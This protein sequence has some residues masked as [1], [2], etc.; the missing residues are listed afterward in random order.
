MHLSLEELLAVRDN[1]AGA[2]AAAHVASCAAC[3]AEVE[4][5]R[6][7]RQELAALGEQRPETDLWQAIV[8]AAA[9]QRQHRRLAVAGWLVAG[10]AA[11][12]TLAIGI[13]GGLEA[14]HEATLARETKQYVA[15]SQRLEERLRTADV[16]GGVMSG[17]TAGGIVQLEDRIGVIDAQLARAGSQRYPSKE[18]LGLWQER[19]QLLGALVNLQTTRTAYMGL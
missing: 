7:V 13:R 12:F 8:S 6:A 5:L 10:L 2:E 17:Q 1:E 16:G 9:A 19:V 3:A 18:V 14:W 4:R 15:E 11:T